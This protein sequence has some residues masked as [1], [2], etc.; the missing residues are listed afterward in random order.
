MYVVAFENIKHIP[1]LLD[2]APLSSRSTAL[3]LR[4]SSPIHHLRLRYRC[5]HFPAGLSRTWLDRYCGREGSLSWTVEDYQYCEELK[6]EVYGLGRADVLSALLIN[7][8][9]DATLPSSFQSSVKVD[10]KQR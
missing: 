5:C 2:F 9:A 10:S 7:Q 1:A 8:S 4:P 6:T 3:V